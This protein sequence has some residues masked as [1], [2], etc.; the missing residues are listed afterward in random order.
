MKK[1][2]LHTYWLAW[3]PIRP[4]NQSVTERQP[5]FQ[6]SWVRSVA[7]P[8]YNGRGIAIRLGA[9]TLSLGV[10]H[11]LGRIT[12]DDDP[13]VLMEAVFGRAVD[14]QEEGTWVSDE[15]SA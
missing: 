3:G 8:Y 15:K 1:V 11:P 13:D 2:W 6:R 10:C 4:S 9:N 7:P 14:K 5:L 12:R